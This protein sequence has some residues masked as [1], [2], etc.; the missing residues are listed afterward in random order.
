MQINNKQNRLH[1]INGAIWYWEEKLK[2]TVFWWDNKTYT[3]E[4]IK[5]QIVF[6][7]EMKNIL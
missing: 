1:Y 2:G 7:K 3:N 6:F 5:S 4:F